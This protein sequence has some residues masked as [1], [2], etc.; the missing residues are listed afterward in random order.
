MLFLTLCLAIFTYILFIESMRLHAFIPLHLRRCTKDYVI[1]D[2]DVLIEK[3]TMVFIPV[4]GFQSDPEYYP[5]PEK[6]DPERFSQEEKQK[7]HPYTFLP[8]GEGPRN[9][10]GL[11]K[12]YYFSKQ[13]L[14]PFTLP[15][16]K[17]NIT[18]SLVPFILSC[19]FKNL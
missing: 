6:F 10:I 5:E 7:R 2:T 4:L 16:R 15:E 18:K 13:T 9:C 12:L 8:F 3:G 19:I 1:P 17:I 11:H 14:I